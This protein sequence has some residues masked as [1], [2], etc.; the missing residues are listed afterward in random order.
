MPHLAFAPYTMTKTSLLFAQKKTED[1]VKEWNDMWEKY[2][3]EYNDLTEEISR[4]LVSNNLKDKTTTWVFDYLG[5]AQILFDK[6][7][8]AIAYDNF[9]NKIESLTDYNEFKTE[10]LK[11]LEEYLGE[12]TDNFDKSDFEQAMTRKRS[13]DDLIDERIKQF[14]NKKKA[15]DRLKKLIQDNYDENDSG[16][17]LNELKKKYEDDIKLADLEWWAFSQISKETDYPIFMAHADEIGYKRGARREEE[18]PNQLF[19]TKETEDGREIVIDIENPKT[20]LDY[21]RRDIIWA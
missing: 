17:V 15:I 4:Y 16:L 3:G 8:F 13:L 12:L 11:F 9:E 21:L 5:V 1:E 18:R 6:N 2:S 10:Y 14:A 19:Q 20:I 7:E